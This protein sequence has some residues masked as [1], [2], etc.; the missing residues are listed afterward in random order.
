MI[1]FYAYFFYQKRNFTFILVS[2][3]LLFIGL[4]VFQAKTDKLESEGLDSDWGTALGWTTA[5]LS[6]LNAIIMAVHVI[7]NRQHYQV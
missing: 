5:C 6:V 1:I 4:A 7:M 2:A 3:S